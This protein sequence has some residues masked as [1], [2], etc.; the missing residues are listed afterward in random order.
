[1]SYT[2]YKHT[3]PSGKV[4]IGIT[5]MA[6]LKR[7]QNGG[8]YRN[9]PYFAAAIQR[10]GW[11][12]I[13]H[14]ILAEGLTREQ[15]EQ[16]EVELIAKY[17]ATDKAFG[18]NLDNG[19]STGGKHSNETRQKIG[20]ANRRRIWTAEAK[21]KVGASSRKRSPDAETRRKMRIAHIGR[22]HTEEAKAKIK[23]AKHKP[24]VCLN[25]GQVYG[26]IE[27]AARSTGAP[28]ARISGVCRGVRK[29][30]RGLSFRFLYQGKEVVS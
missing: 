15:A 18:Y 1:M 11:E 19:G 26:S 2:V 5:S 27:E 28:P 23:A 14:E 22:T 7:W 24:V 17:R 13:Q 6:P 16:M 4:Y 3:S 8:G 21:A 12:N 30:T 29:T 20:A 25:S 10:H 9:N